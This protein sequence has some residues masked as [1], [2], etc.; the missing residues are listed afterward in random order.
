[1]KSCIF[2]WKPEGR[3]LT[4]FLMPAFVICHLF[5]MKGKRHQLLCIP[6][7][8]FFPLYTV[9]NLQ[10]RLQ[11]R[12]SSK[13]KGLE[14]Q[15][16]RT[17]TCTWIC[18]LCFR[19]LILKLLHVVR[20]TASPH[21]SLLLSLYSLWKLFPLITA[22]V[23]ERITLKMILAAKT[24]QRFALTTLGM[25]ITG[26]DLICSIVSNS[27]WYRFDSCWALA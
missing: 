2:I 20:V 14:I 17:Q 7:F 21:G 13:A 15:W 19:K 16:N 5:N 3:E 10:G 24:I 1:M 8:F 18:K 23:S 25:D 4:E 26:I 11:S 27:V 22:E 12:I 6:L 9:Q